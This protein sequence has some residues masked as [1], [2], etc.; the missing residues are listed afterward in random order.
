MDQQQTLT[1]LAA[2]HISFLFIAQHIQTPLPKCVEPLVRIELTTSSL[3]RKCSTPEL[4]RLAECELSHNFKR[5]Y[6]KMLR[7]LT[8]FPIYIG[9]L[10][11]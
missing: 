2:S 11:P 6:F 9:M 8:T 4:Q 7:K 10:Y 3:P 1:G 5:S